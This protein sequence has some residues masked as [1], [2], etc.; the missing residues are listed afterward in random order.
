M[1]VAIFDRVEPPAP[2]EFPCRLTATCS[3]RA[4]AMLLILIFPALLLVCFSATM[5]IVNAALLPEARAVVARHPVLGFEVL[6]AIALIG[7]LLGLPAKR[8]FARLTLAHEV[9]IDAASV[10]VTERSR[11][12]TKTWSQPLSSYTGLAHHVRASL[13]GVRHELILVHPERE[14]SVLVSL[15]ERISQAEVDRVALLM[16]Q[17]E[18]P[19]SALYRFHAHWP[20]LVSLSWRDAA[21]A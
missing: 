7:C 11:F 6:L 10:T 17:K 1:R 9:A 13:S 14:K 16:A 20:R 12:R 5:L 15:A 21:H 4:A 19:A 8:L 3:H 2:I 18:I